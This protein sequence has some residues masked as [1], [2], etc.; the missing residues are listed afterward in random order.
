MAR[1]TGAQHSMEQLCHRV[2]VR[3]SC[4]GKGTFTLFWGNIEKWFLMV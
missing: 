4:V 2:V 1:A 3:G